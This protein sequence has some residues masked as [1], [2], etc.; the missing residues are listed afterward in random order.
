MI[1]LLIGLI[2]GALAA[3]YWS[4]VH[5]TDGLSY[6]MDTD[7][8]VVEPEEIFELTTV[9]ENRKRFMV[10]YLKISERMPRD[11]TLVKEDHAMPLSV[12]GKYEVSSQCY[13]AGRQRLELRRPA[14]ISRRGRYGFSGATLFAGDFL[15]IWGKSRNFPCSHDIVVKPRACTSPDL[16]E[17][18]GGFLG[19]VSVRRFWMEDPMFLLGYRDYTGREPMRS[20]SWTMTAKT[21]RLTVKDFD[22]T[23]E[24]TCTVICDVAGK[25]LRAM[26]TEK[27]EACFSLTRTVCERLEEKGFT[28]GFLSNAMI[29]GSGATL[30]EVFP[31]KG[32]AHLQGILEILG[33]ATGYYDKRRDAET[34]L[35]RLLSVRTPGRACVVISLE[36][37]A[38][39]EGLL[40]RL[41][42]TTGCRTLVLSPEDMGKEERYGAETA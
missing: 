36:G 10:P 30:Q 42:E 17:T 19:E 37:G 31:G 27:Q 5:G 39:C 2:L 9:V 15:G 8:R 22:H 1:V 21:G 3:E 13:L 12:R 20:I 4:F 7:R 38:G 18:L 40:R 6:G 41:E 29:S 16:E 24:P 28:Y 33:R 11:L 23:A 32:Q 34:L 26:G 25:T 35:R 14:R